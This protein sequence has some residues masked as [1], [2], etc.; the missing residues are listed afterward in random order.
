MEKF[1]FRPMFVASRR[2]IRTQDEWNVETHMILAQR[3]S[4]RPAPAFRGSLVG[5]GDGQDLAV[6]GPA[7]GNQVRDPV[8]EHAGLA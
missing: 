1:E 8:A 5:E 6:V 4:P 2:R 3:R 7:R